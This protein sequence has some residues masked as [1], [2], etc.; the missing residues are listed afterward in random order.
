MIYSGISIMGS[1]HNI[2]QDY[3]YTKSYKDGYIMV[4]SDGMGSKSHSHIGS[5]CI[6]ESVYDVIS[7]LKYDLDCISFKD[8]LYFCHNE[9]K[10]R[11]YEYDITKCYATLLVVVLRDGK[12]HAAR[13]GDGFI[14]IYA[15][16]K[17]TCLYDK[18]EDFFVN[19]TECLKEELDRA[20]IEVVEIKFNEFRGV[21][22]CT[23]G[24]EIGT[25]KENEL[26]S[27]A[28]EFIEEYSIKEKDEIVSEIEPWVRSWPS[29]D[30][31]TLAFILKGEK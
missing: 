11:L 27:F 30:D 26:S 17:V 31:K 23:D 4:V 10:K 14:A 9:W 29:S 13:L 22:S 21:I 2:N 19:E 1:Y 18:K 15:D 28:K 8:V 24:I 6:C 5:K 3:F 16:N 20:Q 12:L 25:M 7:N